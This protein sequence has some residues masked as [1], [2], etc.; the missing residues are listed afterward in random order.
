M[1]NLQKLL[2]GAGFTNSPLDSHNLSKLLSYY[3]LGLIGWHSQYGFDLP[4]PSSLFYL[5][6][7]SFNFFIPRYSVHIDTFSC[8][9]P[10]HYPANSKRILDCL[11]SFFD[12]EYELHLGSFMRVSKGFSGANHAEFT[13]GAQAVWS[14]YDQKGNSGFMRLNVPGR[15]LSFQTVDTTWAIM[16]HLF[17]EFKARYTRV[18]VAFDD[19]SRF[20]PMENV[21]NALSNDDYSGIR[22][23]MPYFPVKRTYDGFSFYLGSKKSD[24]FVR[25]YDKNA[26]SKGRINAVRIELQLRATNAENF[27]T[28]SIFESVDSDHESLLKHC[29]DS[30]FGVFDFVDRS[31][32]KNLDRCPRFVWWQKFLDTLLCIPKKN[33]KKPKKIRLYDT[34]SWLHRQVMPTIAACF[35]EFRADF[36][37]YFEFMLSQAIERV[38]KKRRQELKTLNRYL[39]QEKISFQDLLF[40]PV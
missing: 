8:I 22:Q 32:G 31:G 20:F 21:V 9:I 23:Y 24:K 7:I 13:C 12:D 19:Y 1:L 18:D 34:F 10:C 29:I 25:I 33:V 2:D 40:C 37:N 35:L 6:L 39:S 5:R 28:R 4:S 38:P 16:Q 17:S 26:E 27:C 15:Q 36:P 11:A 3:S 30:I 14:H